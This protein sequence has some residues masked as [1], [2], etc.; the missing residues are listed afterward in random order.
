MTDKKSND[1][2]RKLLKSIAAGSG[3]VVAGKSLPE[4]WSKPVI[5][6][7]MLPAH[8]ET[9][10]GSGSSSGDTTTTAPLSTSYSHDL[11]FSTSDGR[12]EVLE[13]VL[14]VLV[15]DAHACCSPSLG[16]MCVD[17]SNAPNFTATVLISDGRTSGFFTGNGTI[18]GGAA[19][20]SIE[21]GCDWWGTVTITVSSADQSGAAYTVTVNNGEQIASGT[22]SVG[23]SCPTNP[24]ECTGG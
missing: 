20:L 8:A 22:A 13:D 21:G 24:G 7:V 23:D 12:N 1:S 18:A 6:S 15:Q 2:R 14:S 10:D 4:S 17:T 11:R 5:N 19:P 3:A 16:A 9:T